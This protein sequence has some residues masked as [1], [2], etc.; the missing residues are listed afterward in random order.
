METAHP[1]KTLA[2]QL[3]STQFHHPKTGLTLLFY[4]EGENFLL[5]LHASHIFLPDKEP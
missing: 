5:L 4:L 3:T 1:F 2:T